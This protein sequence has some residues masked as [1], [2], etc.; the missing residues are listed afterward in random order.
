MDWGVE[1][2]SA[3]CRPMAMDAPQTIMARRQLP[4][5]HACDTTAGA[6]V[7]RLEVALE[8]LKSLLLVAPERRR[9]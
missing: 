2:L 9:P 5:G 3:A 6:A 8:P 1:S 7:T 4:A